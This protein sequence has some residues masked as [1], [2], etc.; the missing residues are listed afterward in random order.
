MVLRTRTDE[1]TVATDGCVIR[2][3]SFKRRPNEQRSDYDLPKMV[4]TAWVLH[5]GDV[6]SEPKA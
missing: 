1:I 5:P 4:G 6:A 2:A 3:R